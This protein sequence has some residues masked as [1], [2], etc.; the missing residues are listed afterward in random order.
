[1][2][3]G[4]MNVAALD[5]T[6]DVDLRFSLEYVRVGAR[7]HREP[8]ALCAGKRFEEAASVRSFRWTKVLAI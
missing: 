3:S 4:L 7:R 5:L 8:L 1:M 2:V 6:C